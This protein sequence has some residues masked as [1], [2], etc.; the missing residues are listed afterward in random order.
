MQFCAY[1]SLSHSGRQLGYVHEPPYSG[2][3]TRSVDAPGQTSHIGRERRLWKSPRKNY[4]ELVT[5]EVN[6]LLVESKSSRPVHAK[7]RTGNAL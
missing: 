6:D 4:R 1:P 7:R 5:S 2:H 3:Q